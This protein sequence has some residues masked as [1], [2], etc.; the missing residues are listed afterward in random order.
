MYCSGNESSEIEHYH[1]KSLFPKKVFIW[2]NMLWACG[3]CNRHKGDFFPPPP[4][5]FINPVDEDVWKYFFIDE[6]GNLC[7]VWKVDL[8]TLDPRAVS[9]IEVM[10]LDRQT[11]QESRLK[12]LLELKEY[13]RDALTLHRQDE[14]SKNDLQERVQKWRESPF[15]PD[16]ADYFLNGPGRNEPPFK[17]LFDVLED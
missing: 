5:A 13:I 1:P 2:E 8:E 7:A 6:F 10:K 12:R 4:K 17:D 11:L 14:L 9:T 15:H 3:I 16:V